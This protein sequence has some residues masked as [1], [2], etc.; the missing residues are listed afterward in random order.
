MTLVVLALA[1]VL[2]LLERN[3]ITGDAVLFLVVLLVPSLVV[4][5]LILFGPKPEANSDPLGQYR[6]PQSTRR[7]SR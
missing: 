7:R 4:D 6:T 3:L 5:L 2:F 1:L